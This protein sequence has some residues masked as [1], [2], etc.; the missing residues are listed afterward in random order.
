[1][2]GSNR[3][4][5]QRPT[6]TR[7]GGHHF[8]LAAHTRIGFDN[9]SEPTRRWSLSSRWNWRHSAPITSVIG[10]MLFGQRNYNI[11]VY[12]LISIY[13]HLT[14]LAATDLFFLPS[15]MSTISISVVSLFVSRSQMME[16][17][18]FS[19]R[20]IAPGWWLSGERAISISV[21]L[22]P[23]T[24]IFISSLP[25]T[26][27]IQHNRVCVLNNGYSVNLC[28]EKIIELFKY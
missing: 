20:R 1:M 27:T 5:W 8:F 6:S 16:N 25:T 26:K 21:S 9:S 19:G 12:Y 15:L 2:W 3:L 4:E 17:V 7:G 22:I 10:F 13:M 24:F 11:L 18:Y 14:F 28:V 23:S